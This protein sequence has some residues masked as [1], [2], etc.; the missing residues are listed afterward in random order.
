MKKKSLILLLAGI[1]LLSV[2]CGKEKEEEK[3]E[4]KKEENTVVVKTLT[5]SQE[6]KNNKMI[7]TLKQD[8]KTYKFT[9]LTAYLEMPEA[10]LLEYGYTLEDYEKEYC[11]N[12]DF[13]SCSA[14]SEGKNIII[15]AA[16]DPEAYEKEILED[17]DYGK[18]DENTLTKLKEE[19]EETGATYT[20]S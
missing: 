3:K 15:E 19:T 18:L 5:C 7:M 13:L 14:R 10:V 1:C 17:E 4:T 20:L 16:Y 6:S 8:M 2:G 12:D 11:T 9:E